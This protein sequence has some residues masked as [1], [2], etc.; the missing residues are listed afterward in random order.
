[1]ALNSLSS[2]PAQV[3]WTAVSIR[4]RYSGLHV[5]VCNVWRL[6]KENRRSKQKITICFLGVGQFFFFFQ[7]R[8][9]MVAL[10]LFLGKNGSTSERCGM[11]KL[12]VHA[13]ENV[14]SLGRTIGTIVRRTRSRPR[15]PYTFIYSV[16]PPHSNIATPPVLFGINLAEVLLALC[17]RSS[18]QF[19]SA[20]ILSR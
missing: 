6:A 7:K 5:P 11:I 20:N 19:S 1:M 10:L 8:N 13:Q 3:L 14:F 18:K 17:Q 16:C 4:L 12:L 9:E 2:K 15:K